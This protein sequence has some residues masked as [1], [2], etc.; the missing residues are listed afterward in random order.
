MQGIL[1]SSLQLHILVKTQNSIQQPTM[2]MRRWAK[3]VQRYVVGDPVRPVRP[4]KILLDPRPSMGPSS[5]LLSQV[6]VNISIIQ[7]FPRNLCVIKTRYK[8]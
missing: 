4:H 1:L 3:S 2:C 7:S 8:M 6:A 5:L